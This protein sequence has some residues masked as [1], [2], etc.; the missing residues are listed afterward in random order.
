ML[1]RKLLGCGLAV[2]VLSFL[3]QPDLPFLNLAIAQ[4]TGGY[5]PV[6]CYNGASCPSGYGTDLDVCAWGP[7]GCPSGQTANG[8]CCCDVSPIVLDVEGDGFSMTNA[9]QG[10]SFTIAANRSVRM[11]YRIS[12]T[13]PGTDDAWLA[14][15]RNG[16]QQI[17]DMTELFGNLTPQPPG[18]TANGFNALAVYDEPIVGGRKDGRIDGNDA[19]FNRL[20][21]WQDYNHNG[22][23]EPFELKSLQQVGISGID[24]DYKESKRQDSFGNKFRYRAKLYRQGKSETGKWA[25]DVYLTVH[26]YPSD[27]QGVS[28]SASIP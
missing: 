4:C 27:F 23:S 17:D 28:S 22:I 7:A 5:C 2:G 18:T 25:W 19:I 21:A 1:F 13:A 3:A 12:W 9:L 14:L 15:D 16:N 11:L 10:V 20:L 8:S 26:R 24:L 6:T